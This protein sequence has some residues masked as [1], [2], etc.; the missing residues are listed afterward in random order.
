MYS[1]YFP[2]LWLSLHSFNDLLTQIH[3]LESVCAG[4][5][6]GG[7]PPLADAVRPRTLTSPS[8]ETKSRR[9]QGRSHPGAPVMF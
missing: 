9:L 6:A 2:T 3:L 4:G 7:E 1:K 8:G 5:G